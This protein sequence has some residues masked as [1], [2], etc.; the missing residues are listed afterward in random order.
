MIRFI[1]IRLLCFTMIS[2]AFMQECPP[3]DTLSINPIQNLWNIPI[4]NQWDRIE[5]MTWNIKNFPISNNTIDYVNEI[6]TDL[7]PDIIAFQEIN[8][9]SAFNTLANGIPAY[10]FIASGSGL[11]LAVRSD[12]IEIIS[13]STLFSNA[14]YEFAWRYPLIVE[15][16]WLCGTNATHLYIINVHLKAGSDNEDFDRRYS[17]CQYL[18][19]YVNDNLMDNII[20]L[21]DYNDEITDSQNNNSLWPLVSDNSVSFATD[22]IANIDYYASYPSWP[23]FI[24]HIAL[25]ENLFDELIGGNIKTIR[26]DDYTGYSFYQDYISDHRPVLWSFEIEEVE[27]A[28]G[29]VINEIM[30]NPVVSSDAA[31]EWIEITNVSDVE[32]SLNGLI[33]KDDSDEE[34]IISDNM[35]TVSPGSFVVLGASDD[36]SLNGQI[37]VDYVYSGINLSNLW[38]E[39]I[40]AYPSGIVI[41]EVHY[42]NGTTFPDEDGKSMMLFSPNLDNS[43]G[44]NWGIANVTFGAGDY[45]TPGEPN[46]TGECPGAGD[47]NE[48]G[49]HNVL[50]VVALV[51]CVLS[52]DCEEY[53]NSC[54]CDFNGDGAYNVLDI[55]GLA[56]CVL[57]DN[58]D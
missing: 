51:N 1:G 27:S 45:G 11:A 26:I 30:Q 8:N 40:L 38:D 25:S 10:E 42:D 48:D 23:S 41:D 5:V 7:T 13:W 47:I 17:S 31:G 50:D 19:D 32:I 28:T 34:H 2:W 6:I 54:V 49:Q 29:L 35:L 37:N 55:V 57:L 46:W 53:E 22:P 9:I 15:L 3:S 39:V 16:N 52:D 33:L 21:G 36:Q 56:N 14:G 12:V 18:S 24:D 58:C 20:I 43:L 4:E 44:E